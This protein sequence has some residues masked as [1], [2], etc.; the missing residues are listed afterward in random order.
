MRRR[1][2]GHAIRRVIIPRQNHIINIDNDGCE[3]TSNR[4]FNE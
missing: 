3:C 1:H 4:L 2:K